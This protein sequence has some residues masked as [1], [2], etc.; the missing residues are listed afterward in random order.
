MG[1]SRT[2]WRP[3]NSAA[4]HSGMTYAVASFTCYF[5]GKGQCK[6]HPCA[7]VVKKKRSA[8]R[9]LLL[10][11]VDDKLLA[12]RSLHRRQVG[13]QGASDDMAQPANSES[14]YSDDE[15][16]LSCFGYFQVCSEHSRDSWAHAGRAAAVVLCRGS[17]PHRF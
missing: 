10:F 2:L 9:S 3:G 12:N 5:H 13:V 6:A 8:L 17:R 16:E 1:A 14:D 11:P 7:K 15:A 4:A